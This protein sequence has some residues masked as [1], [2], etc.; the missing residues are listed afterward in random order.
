V[1][2]PAQAKRLVIG[3]LGVA[4]IVAAVGDLSSGQAPQ[5]R[6]FIGACIAGAVL[7]M[8]AEVQPELAA[9]LALLV[10]LSA[11]IAGG[12]ATIEKVA[13]ATSGSG[14]TPAGEANRR[15][16]EERTGRPGGGGASGTY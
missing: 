3:G 14:R 10:L 7:A 12:P 5:L 8:V 13:G 4:G 15:R 2:T 16:Q 9:G 6:I 11:A 1:T